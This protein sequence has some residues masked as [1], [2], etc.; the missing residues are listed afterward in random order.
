MDD[1]PDYLVDE[2]LRLLDLLR[3]NPFENDA[4]LT[5]QFKDLPGRPGIYAVKHCSLGI[6]YIGRSTNIR[7]RLRGGH[8]ALGWA[9]ID[10]LDPGD[11][12]VACTTLTFQW[13]RVSY[14]LEQIMIKRVQPPYSDR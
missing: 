1:Y 2:A 10:R 11:V 7:A 9:F 8:K 5:R 12:R 14:E 13:N 4:P 6:L 3:N